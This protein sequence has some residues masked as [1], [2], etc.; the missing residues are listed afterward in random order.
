MI[1]A[2][3]IVQCPPA[4][5]LDLQVVLHEYLSFNW[6]NLDSVYEVN[7]HLLRED[8]LMCTWTKSLQVS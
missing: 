1:A 5:S 3:R 2:C 8:G 4:T 7:Q 6:K